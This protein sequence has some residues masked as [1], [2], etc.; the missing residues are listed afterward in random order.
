MPRLDLT[1]AEQLRKVVIDPLIEALRTEMRQTVG[2]LLEEMA[3][4][5]RHDEDQDQRVEVIEHRLAAVERF[6]L[7]IAT[8]CSGIAIM[9]G[10][11]W[12]TILD[13]ARRK[14]TR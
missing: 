5:R 11:V 10:I 12:R 7:R 4:L 8:V 13:W 6:K 9:A 3:R 1:D 2:P 14:L